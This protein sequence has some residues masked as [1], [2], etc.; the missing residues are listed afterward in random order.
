MG[1]ERRKEALH[2]TIRGWVNY[3][4][5]DWKSDILEND[6][7]SDAAVCAKVDEEYSIQRVLYSYCLIKWLEQF[8]P[9]KTDAEIFDQHFG[10]IYYVFLRGTQEGQSSGIYAHTWKSFDDLQKSFDK[11]KVLMKK[12]RAQVQEGGEDDE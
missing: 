5:L 1:Y 6:I 10:G 4:I 3:F 7:Y 9:K 8:Y 12:K 2:Q 11:L